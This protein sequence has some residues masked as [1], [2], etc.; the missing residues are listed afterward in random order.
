MNALIFTFNF[1][2]QSLQTSISLERPSKTGNSLSET[3]IEVPKGQRYAGCCVP[4]SGTQT[5]ISLAIVKHCGHTDKFFIETDEVNNEVIVAD[6]DDDE[7]EEEYDDDEEDD[8][9]EDDDDEDE[10]DDDD[11]DDSSSS[12]TAAGI[13]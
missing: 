1:K 12:A 9:D 3:E 11:D 10:V 4:I 5:A 13:L 8:D 2:A 6:D 7:E